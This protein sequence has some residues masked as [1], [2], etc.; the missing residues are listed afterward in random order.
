MIKAY[1]RKKD[2]SRPV[3]IWQQIET[4]FLRLIYQDYEKERNNTK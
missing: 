1:N 3:K 4:G 2:L